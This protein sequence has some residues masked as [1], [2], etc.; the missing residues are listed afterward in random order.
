[1]TLKRDD[2]RG[3]LLKW[4]SNYLLYRKQRVVIPGAPS[5]WSSVTAGASHGSIL[6]PFLFLIFMNELLI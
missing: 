4:F 2:I 6:G 1:M 5:D 3:S